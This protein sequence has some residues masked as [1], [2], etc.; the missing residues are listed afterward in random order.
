M[1]DTQARTGIENLSAELKRLRREVDSALSEE[2][3]EA[4]MGLK[5]VTAELEQ[6]RREVQSTLSTDPD[7]SPRYALL[8]FNGAAVYERLGNLEKAIAE[9]LAHLKLQR[10]VHPARTALEPLPEPAETPE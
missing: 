10:V 3:T 7:V 9:L 5:K 4:R 1:K 6:F 8:T 2:V